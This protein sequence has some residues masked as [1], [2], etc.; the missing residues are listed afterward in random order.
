MNY[1]DHI[2]NAINKMGQNPDFRVVGYNC[3][4][5]GGSGGGSF[6]GVPLSQRIEMPLAEALMASVACGMSLAGF[7]VMLWHERADF[8]FHS[9]D[10]ICNHV[11]Q[12]S[13]LSNGIH[14][15][16][17]IYRVCVGNKHSPLYTGPTHTRNMASAMREMVRFPVIELKWASSIELEY[18]RAWDRMLNERKST[19]LVEFKDMYQDQ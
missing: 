11:D 13:D 18:Q 12:L 6:N 8:L 15:P 10:S 5:P 16:A 19:M 4:P 17:I 1:R 3:T 14:R 2:V 9:L 7:P